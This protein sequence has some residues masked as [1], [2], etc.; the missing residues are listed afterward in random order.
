MITK[1]VLLGVTLGSVAL[2]VLSCAT[3]RPAFERGNASV[4]GGQWE[5][6]I[7]Q[8]QEALREEP[9][10]PDY[11][12][13]LEKTKKGA[14]KFYY[15]KAAKFLQSP[16]V[17][18]ENLQAAL[19]ELQ[20]ATDLAPNDLLIKDSTQRTLDDR[21]ALEA[22]INSHFRKGLE[23]GNNQRWGEALREYQ[24]ALKMNPSS[25]R[26]RAKLDEAVDGLAL[27]YFNKGVSFQ[28]EERWEEA[29][30]QFD[31]SLAIKPNYPQ[32]LREKERSSLELAIS[33]HLKAGEQYF[34]V[35][36]WDKVIVE[37]EAVLK[38]RQD[39]PEVEARLKEA[40][41][42]K[43]EPDYILG[44]DFEN[45]R[46]WE[47]AIFQYQKV[48]AVLPDYEDVRIRLRRV[49][50]RGADEHYQKATVYEGAGMWGN[51]AVEFIR[52]LKLVPGFAEGEDKLNLM[53]DNLKKTS[54]FFIAIPTFQNSSSE[55]EIGGALASDLSR[56]IIS[57]RP[58]GLGV[59]ERENLEKVLEEQ[60]L[61]L[62]G[63]VDPLKI[64][65]L[66]KLV[67][68]DAVL[69]GNVIFFSVEDK[70]LSKEYRS[71]DYKDPTR[72]VKNPQFES[73]KRASETVSQ[74][75]SGAFGLGGALVGAVG[76]LAAGAA[77]P[78][79]IPSDQVYG[80]VE[81]ETEREAFMQ[82]N[83]NMIDTETG[84]YHDGFESKVEGQESGM[85]YYLQPTDE[86][87]ISR[88]K[89]AEVNLDSL[90]LPSDDELKRKVFRRVVDRLT[91]KV[92]GFF[93]G[94]AQTYYDRG[95]NYV[96]GRQREEAIEEFMKVIVLTPQSQLAK[97]ARERVKELKGFEI[98]E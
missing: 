95:Q 88:A 16:E 73:T 76:Q 54:T 26:I 79:Y 33:K 31:E 96:G 66:G 67:S 35:K 3:G 39:Y 59:V 23:E 12:A 48:A 2:L 40:K 38:L 13:A 92:I 87:D 62:G 28:K 32:A 41:I 29:I 51:A 58:V 20:K 4:E 52:V 61:S 82:V 49:T 90:N 72:K 53:E 46:M 5:R 34:A 25:V 9:N 77:V 30:A 11:Q 78:E 22:M 47:N 1:R 68:A 89:L 86:A 93:K 17:T 7:E 94:R 80:Y 97:D 45:K 75:L 65:E 64:K 70:E 43:I 18:L 37:L 44:T 85:D 91:D 57:K 71:K 24:V 84:T 74:G 10:N 6:A 98:S 36:E 55:S 69:L 83:V 21:K 56:N 15:D 19:V 14:A 81:G 60:K 42:E 63:F 50:D 8:Y 27:D